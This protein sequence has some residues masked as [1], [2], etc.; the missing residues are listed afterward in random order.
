MVRG[1]IREVER[2][3][4]GKTQTRRILKL[5][6]MLDPMPDLWEAKK[7]DGVWWFVS[8]HP[9]CSGRQKAPVRFAKGD[10]LY[11]R[12]AWAEVGTYDP[13]LIVT[14]ADY[15]ACVP[16]HYE[17]V[18]PAGEVKWRPGIHMPRA[19]SRLTLT[20]T[21]VRVQRLQEISEADAIAE[22]ATS[23]PNCHGFEDRDDGWCMD[24]TR[25]GQASKWASDGKT[26]HERD[27]CLATARHAFAN[28]F[29]AINGTASWNANPWVVAV[30]FTVEKRN[31][32][33]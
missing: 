17:N 26:L 8:E 9:D 3:G 25:V 5:D 27:V 7:I 32:D 21:D 16:R 13:G 22:G 12:E 11:V 23:R 10:R 18:P 30:A 24:W 2:P 33:R 4:A 15:P 19:G 6:G 14:R 29:D 20:V 28:V 31:I 1:L